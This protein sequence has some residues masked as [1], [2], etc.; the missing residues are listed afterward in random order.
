MATLRA[1]SNGTYRASDE[2]YD[3]Y[4][5]VEVDVPIS[6]QLGTKTITAN[7]TYT[8]TDDSLDGYST[9]SVEVPDSG[10]E[11]TQNF[12]MFYLTPE[13]CEV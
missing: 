7:G 1:T 10:S 2:D 3:G 6:G 8:A 4:S 12:E 5:D 9:V 11:G 13:F